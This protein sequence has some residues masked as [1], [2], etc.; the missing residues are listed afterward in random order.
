V[1]RSHWFDRINNVANRYTLTFCGCR[2][3]RLMPIRA[4]WHTKDTKNREG[5]L[6]NPNFPVFMNSE[7]EKSN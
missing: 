2:N 4:I 3:L 1:A 5:L 6:T 7:S